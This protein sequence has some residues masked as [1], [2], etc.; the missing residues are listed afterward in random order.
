MNWPNTIAQ[1]AIT[2]VVCLAIA[3]LVYVMI[4]V[5]GIPIPQWFWTVCFIVIVAVII[6]AAI[7]FVSRMGS[8]P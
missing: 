1:W 7:R 2:I 3:G 4:Q 6:I 8:N 5:T